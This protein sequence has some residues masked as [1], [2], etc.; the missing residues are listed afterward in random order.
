MPARSVRGSQFV[1]QHAHHNQL[2]LWFA[3]MAYVLLCALR[4]IGLAQTHLVRAGCR[5]IW[6]K[7]LEIA[8]L[9]RISVRRIKFHHNLG[10]AIPERIQSCPC[11]IIRCRHSNGAHDSSHRARISPLGMGDGTARLAASAKPHTP[12]MPPRSMLLRFRGE[13]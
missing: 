11:A 12:S 2:R 8:A 7:L 13:S 1:L 4:R 5:S 3:F 6:L 9:V 10:L